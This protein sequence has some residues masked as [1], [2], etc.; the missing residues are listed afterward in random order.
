MKILIDES[1]PG[2]LRNALPNHD[3]ATVAD[4]GWSGMTNAALLRRAARDFDA[5]LTLDEGLNYQQALRGSRLAILALAV[6]SSRLDDLLPL[7][8]QIDAALQRIQPGDVVRL[9]L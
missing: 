5:F 8:P 1:L 4:L 3:I 6:L 2:N 9:A 7:V